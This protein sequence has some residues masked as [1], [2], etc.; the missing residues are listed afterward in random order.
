M[1][2]HFIRPFLRLLLFILVISCHGQVKTNLPKDNII[3]PKMI[4]TQGL[5][6]GNVLCKLQDKFSN[7]WFGT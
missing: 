4:R 3:F 2:T 1:I 6:S 5:V 7:L